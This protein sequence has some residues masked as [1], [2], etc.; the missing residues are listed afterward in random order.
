MIPASTFRGRRVAVFG[1]GRSGG[2]TCRALAA[3]GAH[4]LAWDDTEAGRGRAQAD[5]LALTDL[6]AADWSAIDALVLAPGVPLTHPAPHWTVARAREAGVEVIGDIE[7]FARERAKIS[8]DAPFVAITGT[9]G[10]STTTALIAHILRSLGR[11]TQMGG[12]IGVPILALEPPRPDR[13]YVVEMSS[14][15][16]DLTPTLEMDVGLLLNVSPDHIDRHGTYANYAAIKARLAETA[17]LAV[18]GVDDPTVAEIAARLVATG[19]DVLRFSAGHDLPDGFYLDRER[20]WRAR[21]GQREAVANLDGLVTLRGRHNAANL[22]AALAAVEALGIPLREVAP[23]LRTFPGLAHRLEMIGRAGRVQFI[24]DSKATNGEA[25]AVALATFPEGIYWIVGGRA[26][27]GGL[28]GL[29]PYFP[30]IARAYL[31]G[32]SQAAFEAELAGRVDTV[33][34]GTLD[35]AIARAAADAAAD[36]AAEPVVLLAPACAS[37]DQYP[38]FEVRGDHFRQLVASVRGFEPR[39][40]PDSKRQGG[41]S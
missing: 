37:F 28:A 6:A 34:C 24:N 39:F 31:V 15:Q 40:A 29:E 35:V 41:S 38:G 16:I 32:E 21:D 5:G 8:P 36:A 27:E 14:Y 25:A 7:I 17:R 30:R 26:K 12:N 13:F 2:A 11:D 3:G 9:N 19:H 33:T 23:T 18:I 4:A 22:M 20:I 1:L 10:K